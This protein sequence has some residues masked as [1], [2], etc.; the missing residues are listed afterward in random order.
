MYSTT[1]QST[2]FFIGLDD[3]NVAVVLAL[4]RFFKSLICTSYV[5]SSMN[6]L[7]Q[8]LP[9]NIHIFYLS[10]DYFASCLRIAFTTKPSF[11]FSWGSNYSYFIS[12]QLI[13][14]LGL[15]HLSSSSQCISHSRYSRFNILAKYL[16]H[17]KCKEFAIPSF[18]RFELSQAFLSSSMLSRSAKPIVLKVDSLVTQG[19][20][21]YSDQPISDVKS[22][23]PILAEHIEL[24]S[25]TIFIQDYIQGGHYSVD[26]FVVRGNPL[27]ILLGEKSMS[28]DDPFHTEKVRYNHLSIEYEELF[29]RLVHICI[30]CFS[31]QN[32]FLHLELCIS[33]SQVY[34]I[35][36]TLRPPGSLSS[37]IIYPFISGFNLDY[38]FSV[39][40]GPDVDTSNNINKTS[41]KRKVATLFHVDLSKYGQYLSHIDSFN[42]S[43]D[44]LIL[45]YSVDHS[46]LRPLFSYEN[47]KPRSLILA[48][49]SLFKMNFCT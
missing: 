37:S 49:G 7:S 32:E 36:V 47:K 13:S 40:L 17:I 26:A 34:L 48:I 46:L 23:L 18:D 15:D 25:P 21:L 42:L 29:D 33:D 6:L 20:C 27:F 19:H 3:S 10:T 8:K 45:G 35:D 38:L 12:C 43:K 16:R 39:L 24:N 4:S 22:F 31:I 14:I 44:P 11:V 30:D 5:N 41:S 1:E 28:K 2:A 9:E